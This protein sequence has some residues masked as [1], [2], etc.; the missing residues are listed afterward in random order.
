MTPEMRKVANISDAESKAYEKAVQDY[1]R[2]R[3]SL[4]NK[5]DPNK[6]RGT[7]NTLPTFNPF[8]LGPNQN[9]NADPLNTNQFQ[10]P[11]E[12]RD[13]QREF[14]RPPETGKKK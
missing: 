1:E 10:P 9:P 12:F 7:K 2:N 14:T 11:P 8:K 6:S 5:S 3:Q 4:A 13:A